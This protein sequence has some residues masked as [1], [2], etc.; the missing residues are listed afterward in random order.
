MLSDTMDAMLPGR[1]RSCCAEAR[2]E[3]PV[4]SS[5]DRRHGYGQ[6]AMFYPALHQNA[7][8]SELAQQ[9]N[10]EAALSDKA[11]ALGIEERRENIRQKTIKLG[12][13]SSF[14]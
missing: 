2:R 7:Q 1:W 11:A 14:I 9:V 6:G 10:S 3:H 4:P 8:T 12:Y 5:E 13:I